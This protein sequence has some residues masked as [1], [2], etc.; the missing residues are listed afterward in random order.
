MKCVAGGCH[1]RGGSGPELH[2]KDRNG[3]RPELASKDRSPYHVP[4]TVLTR[5]SEVHDQSLVLV[6]I[7][8]NAAAE[9][10]KL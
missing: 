6:D 2:S 4:D 7:P 3:S 10:K 8:I 5:V 1:C 9:H